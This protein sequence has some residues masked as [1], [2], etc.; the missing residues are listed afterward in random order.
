M[1]SI[2]NGTDYHPSNQ[3]LKYPEE[4]LDMISVFSEDDRFRDEYN[5]NTANAKGEITMCEIYDKI[6]MEGEAK[7]REEG[8]A[9]GIAKGRLSVLAD[10]VKNGI[11]TI[12]QAAEQE[13]MSV[14]EFSKLT[15][16]AVR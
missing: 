6:L 8:E 15:G 10:L 7:G 2:N 14:E 13:K 9:I 3:V 4:T 11:I 5:A 12:M 1:H 16:L